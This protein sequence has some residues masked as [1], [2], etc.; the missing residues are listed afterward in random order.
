ML[1]L[2]GIAV[3]TIL[4]ASAALKVW[5]IQIRIWLIPRL[6]IEREAENLRRTLGRVGARRK[7]IE[8]IM[9]ALDQNNIIEQG[10]WD[11]ILASLRAL[12]EKNS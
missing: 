3:A 7:A 2:G 9:A 6:E 8:N 11:R 4:L 10:R 1:A 12:E 5:H